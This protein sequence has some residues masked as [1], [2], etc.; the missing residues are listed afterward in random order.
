[1]P[2]IVKK[3]KKHIYHPKHDKNADI[4]KIYNSAKWQ[5]LRNA[6]LMEHPL[7]ERCLEKGIIKEAAEIHHKKPIS[8]GNSNS[9]M[10]EIA[11]DYDNLMSLCTECHHKIHQEMR[12]KNNKRK[13]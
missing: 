11:Y 1:M 7:C 3:P 10:R 5:K 13:N 2:Y 8:T 9:E 6:Y 12:R 4:A